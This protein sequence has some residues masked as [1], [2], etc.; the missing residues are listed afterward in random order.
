MRFSSFVAEG[1]DNSM[2]ELSRDAKQQSDFDDDPD[3]EKS[4]DA[5]VKQEPTSPPRQW[6]AGSQEDYE[7]K[8]QSNEYGTDYIDTFKQELHQITSLEQ[9]A[10]QEIKKKT[11]PRKRRRKEEEG[12]YIITLDSNGIPVKKL[13]TGRPKPSEGERNFVCEICDARFATIHTLNS[14]KIIHSGEKPYKCE[15]CD[16]CFARTGDRKVHVTQVHSQEKPFVCPTCGFKFSRRGSLHRHLAVHRDDKPFQCDEC[17]K[18]F[19]RNSDLRLHRKNHFEDRVYPYSCDQ[20]DKQF[21]NIGNLKHHMWI[22][23]G[24]KM[25]QCEQCSSSFA[26]AKAIKKHMLRRHDSNGIKPVCELC[27]LNVGCTEVEPVIRETED[28]KKKKTFICQACDRGFAK[29][30]TLR[31]HMHTHK[32]L[33]FEFLCAVC[34]KTCYTENKASTQRSSSPSTS[35]SRNIFSALGDLETSESKSEIQAVDQAPAL[36]LSQIVFPGLPPLSLNVPSTLDESK[37]SDDAS[38]SKESTEELPASSSV[39]KQSQVVF[40]GMEL[41]QAG[42]AVPQA[43]D[44]ISQAEDTSQAD[45]LPQ[46]QGPMSQ[47]GDAVPQAQDTKSQVEDA[48]PQA[49]GTHPQ[50]EGAHPRAEGAHLQAEGAHPQ[51]EGALPQAEGALPQAEGSHPQAEDALP[52][53]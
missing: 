2:E 21:S 44:S 12:E 18:T 1:A 8:L 29:I 47:A 7:A 23:S 45:A 34:E 16:K 46:P 14:H 19:K 4:V 36:K 11:K 32:T 35:T 51:A 33:S 13:I 40:P 5:D 49:E 48:L 20:C 43:Q 26:S 24:E 17:F 38:N 30:F 6:V 52:Q 53:A 9:E 3:E 31:R 50:A 41:P 22:H 37:P 28:G 42:D 15:Y 27:I 25:Y 10:K 39:P